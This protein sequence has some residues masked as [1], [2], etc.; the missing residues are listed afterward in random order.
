MTYTQLWTYTNTDHHQTRTRKQTQ[1]P[2]LCDDSLTTC[3]RG[4]RCWHVVAIL[5]QRVCVCVNVDPLCQLSRNVCVCLCVNVDTLLWHY[6]NVCVRVSVFMLTSCHDSLTT[7][8]SVCSDNTL[9]RL[10]NNACLCACLCVDVNT[11]WHLFHNV[12]ECVRVFVFGSRNSHNVRVRVH[13]CKSWHVVTPLLQCARVCVFMLTG[14]DDACTP[15]A[16]VYS[17]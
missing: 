1:S 11:L 14:C 12:C 8:V 9:W 5:S 15:C 2:T 13:V 10:P 17:R 4:C 7:C 6:Y 3:M 16:S